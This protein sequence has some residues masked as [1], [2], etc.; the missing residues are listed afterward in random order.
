VPLAVGE[1]GD[2][3]P[4][5]QIRH[6]GG[7]L[8]LV[9]GVDEVQELP[10]LQLCD[11]VAEDRLPGGIDAEEDA[12][13]VP[14]AEHVGGEGEELGELLCRAR[15]LDLSTPPAQ[16]DGG[17]VGEGLELLSRRIGGLSVQRD[18]R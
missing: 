5:R 8:G 4:V 6:A 10:A 11:A 14:D 3:A 13:R 7:C 16:R 18:D 9:V 1:V 15:Q 12:R 17:E 2:R